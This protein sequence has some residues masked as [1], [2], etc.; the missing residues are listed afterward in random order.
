MRHPAPCCWPLVYYRLAMNLQPMSFWQL[1]LN[2]PEWALVFVGILT[3]IFIGWQAV[4]TRRAA[5]ATQVSAV[6]IQQQIVV[7]E[8]QTKATEDAAAAAKDTAESTK[9]SIEMMI[10][11]ERAWV[12]ADPGSIPDD[13]EPRPDRIAFLEVRPVIKNYG[14]TM[15]RITRAGISSDIVP[16]TG[17]L[18]PEPKYKYEQSVDIVLP[19]D[20]PIQALKIMI[21]QTDFIAARQGDTTLYVYGF[22]DYVDFGQKP[23]TS[24]FCFVYLVPSG[25]TSLKRGF[26]F[27]GDVPEAYTK[28]T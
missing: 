14:K 10:S 6:A 18:Q 27:S 21:P 23:R 22:I 24:K 17:K 11:S 15:T 3:L 8:R 1:F 12:L 7:M 26:Y 25:F 5:Q 28:C 2:N 4:E 16:S 13:F 19:P 9:L 20:V